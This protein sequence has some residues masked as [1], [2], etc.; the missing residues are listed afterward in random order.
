MTIENKFRKLSDRIIV[1]QTIGENKWNF[2]LVKAVV[3]RFLS[4]FLYSQVLDRFQ[5]EAIASNF[6]NCHC[7]YNLSALKAFCPTFLPSRFCR[8][9]FVPDKKNLCIWE[10]QDYS[11]GDGI[12]KRRFKAKLVCIGIFSFACTQKFNSAYQ[13]GWPRK[14][15]SNCL[16][17]VILNHIWMENFF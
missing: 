16:S 8:F 11:V 5:H 7:S 13:D 6:L 1:A 2:C 4:S 17:R 15:L 10:F 12:S 3:E 9:F 14:R